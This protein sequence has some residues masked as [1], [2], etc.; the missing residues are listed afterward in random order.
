[1]TTD[2]SGRREVTR[3]DIHEAASV[4]AVGIGLMLV[5][6]VIAMASLATE[7]KNQVLEAVK[8]H[9]SEAR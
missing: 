8:I 3:D 6:C 4:L 2:T 1:M 7:Y 5:V 9:C